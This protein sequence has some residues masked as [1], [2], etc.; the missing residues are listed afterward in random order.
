MSV[1]EDLQH[2]AKDFTVK[3]IVNFLESKGLGHYSQLFEEYEI[4]GELLVQFHDDELSDIGIT[5]ALDRLRITMYFK[6]LVVKSDGIAELYPVEAVVQF[7]EQTRPLQQFAESFREQQIDGELLL[8][9]S[10]DAMNELGVV[11][12]VHKMMIRQKFKARLD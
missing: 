2:R 5:S 9:A 8:N 12:G 3:D 7:L 4:N 10:D 6:R 1:G 11:K